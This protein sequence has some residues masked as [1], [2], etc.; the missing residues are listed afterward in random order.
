MVESI[1]VSLSSLRSG[2]V[3]PICE[4]GQ[5]FKKRASRTKIHFSILKTTDA[6]LSEIVFWSSTPFFLP[7]FPSP[8]PF[9]EEQ[10]F[11]FW[12]TTMFFPTKMVICRCHCDGEETR[13]CNLLVWLILG[14]LR[15]L[16]RTH[17]VFLPL[18]PPLWR[19]DVR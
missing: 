5:L 6:S 8:F 17:L 3:G 2:R 14:S 9:N 4:I 19:A 12:R 13:F 15:P 11:A 16:R 7:K 10:L 1:V 18:L